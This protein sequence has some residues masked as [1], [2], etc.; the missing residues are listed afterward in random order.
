ME[1]WSI[2]RQDPEDLDSLERFHLECFGRG[3]DR[4]RWRWFNQE[5]PA[6][7]VR[8]WIATERTSG[9]IIATYSLLPIKI[10]VGARI[11]DASLAVNAAVLPR[12]R[13]RGLFVDLGGQGLAQERRDGVMLTLGKPNKSALA[14]H[15]R[16]GW[17]ELCPL[18]LLVLPAPR[19]RPHRCQPLGAFDARFDALLERVAARTSLMVW[20]DARWMAWRCAPPDRRYSCWGLERDGILAGTAILKHYQGPKGIVTHLLSLLAQDQQARAELLAAAES[21][22]VGTRE[23]NLWT[24]PHDPNADPLRQA[25]WV[26]RPGG[27]PL[28][29][30][31]DLQSPLLPVEGDW[32]FC[33]ADVDV[34]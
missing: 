21:F 7:P 18:D 16:V 12:W 30:H 13:R 19:Q 23:L 31:Q 11:L 4:A 25:G 24:H 6:G 28:I 1:P 15:R 20:K 2:R 27:Q 26:Q 34:F 33:Y 22:A 8:A 5:A 14:G 3:L 29:V 32:S 9:Q 10:K 17:S